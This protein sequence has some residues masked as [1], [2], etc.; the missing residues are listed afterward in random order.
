MRSPAFLS[1]I[2][3]LL[4][5]EWAGAQTYTVKRIPENTLEIT[6]RGDSKA[7]EKATRLTDFSYP[8][9]QENA[10]ATSFAALWDGKWLYCLYQATDDSIIT[11]VIKN[12][13]MDAGAADRVEI[14]MARDT[15]LLP[16]YYC[17]EM[18]AAGRTLDYRASFYRK[19][20]YTWSWPGK[21]FLIKTATTTNGYIVEIAISIQSLNDL[22]LL[23]NQR[24]L[25]GLFRA[26]R[27]TA[28]GGYNAFHWISWVKPNATQPDFHIP[29]AFGVL[30][31]E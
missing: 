29:S 19:M 7:W 1:L 13:K 6:G 3:A 24:L 17:L 23:P 30:V 16:F 8:W 28:A 2:T 25:A 9:E 18:D 10:P 12:N 11:P 27:K 5:Y 26:E 4:I 21:Q 14:F 20:D 31:L 22:G 15:T